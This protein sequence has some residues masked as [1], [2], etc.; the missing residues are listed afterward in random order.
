[1]ALAFDLPKE[2]EATRPAE[3]RGLPRDGV[4]L[5]VSTPRGNTHRIARFVDIAKYLRAGDL[6]VV[7]DSA[8]IPA[9]LTARRANGSSILLHLSTRISQTL[10]IVEPRHTLVEVGERLSLPGDGSIELLAPLARAH[11]RLWYAVLRINGDAAAYLHTHARPISYGYLDAEVGIDAYQTIFARV[12]GSVEMPSAARPFTL[13][14]VDALYRNNVHIAAITLHCGVASPESHEPPV[15][16]R[17]NVPAPTAALVNRTRESGGRVIAAGTTVVRALESA[18][19]SSGGVRPVSG[20]TSHLVDPQHPPRAVDGLLTGFHEPRASHL[21]M[22]E[23]F[24]PTPFL[25]E[26]YDTAIDAG[27]LWHEFGD[28]HLVLK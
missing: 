22:L 4:Q 7:N 21:N 24:V 2:R 12:P 16:E 17:F 5:L 11:T 3:L 18:V 23:A 6:L 26:A 25:K 10:W 28:V 9:A 15:D 27:L 20:W 14:V 8:T 13:R 19:D 1:L